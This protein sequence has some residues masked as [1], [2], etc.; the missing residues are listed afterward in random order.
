MAARRIRCPSSR[1]ASTKR[2]ASPAKIA[3][4]R[5]RAFSG[6]TMPASR[7]LPNPT[8]ASDGAIIAGG[9]RMSRQ[10]DNR[11]RRRK[12]NTA[13]PATQKVAARRRRAPG[14]LYVAQ[15]ANLAAAEAILAAAGERAGIVAGGFDA[16]SGCWVAASV[17]GAVVGVA[18]IETIV[19]AAV[20][21]SLAVVEAMRRRGIASELVKA[22][23][24]AA[25]TRGARRLYA[26]G[27]RG[28]QIFAALRIRAGGGGG[29][30]GRSHGH[31]H[32]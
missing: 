12:R 5:R 28:E 3:S 7:R 16:P 18:G 22:A 9:S 29:N 31:L 25:H 15:T 19:D 11:R 27:R 23:R 24:K 32:R 14:E 4:K 21:R 6:S 2:N 17:D 10:G 1:P 30:D 8:G 13:I 26:L 20:I